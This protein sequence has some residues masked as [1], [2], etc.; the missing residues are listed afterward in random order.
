MTI[1]KEVKEICKNSKNSTQE[2]SNLETGIKNKLL[3]EISNEIKIR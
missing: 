2:I 3:L 1:K